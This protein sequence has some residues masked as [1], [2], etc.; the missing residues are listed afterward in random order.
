M[1]VVDKRRPTESEQFWVHAGKISVNAML[2]GRHLD[3]FL[4]EDRCEVIEAATAQPDHDKWF[5]AGVRVTLKQMLKADAQRLLKEPDSVSVAY[6]ALLKYL[7]HLIKTDP[8]F[9]I[10]AR[11]VPPSKAVRKIVNH[12]K[13]GRIKSFI[14]VEESIV[15]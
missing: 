15:I 5:N 3:D 12:D 2:T 8:K 13:T 10:S 14:E 4:I 9:T 11:A 1:R 6:G 7:A